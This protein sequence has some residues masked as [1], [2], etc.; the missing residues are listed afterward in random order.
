M[1]G[2]P[3]FSLPVESGG[4]P[5]LRLARSRTYRQWLCEKGRAKSP[6][7]RSPQYQGRLSLPSNSQSVLLVG[8]LMEVPLEY[9]LIDMGLGVAFVL[10]G[11]ARCRAA[12]PC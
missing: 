2:P 4:P 11:A 3:L 10:D 9:F 1:Q 5:G 12:R 8:Q 6:I 7:I